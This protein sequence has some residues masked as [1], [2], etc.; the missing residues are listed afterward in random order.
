MV[1]CDTSLFRAARKNGRFLLCVLSKDPGL[2]PRP[3]ILSLSPASV[4]FV[5]ETAARLCSFANE[6][7]RPHNMLLTAFAT[8]FPSAF[9]KPLN[10]GQSAEHLS[11]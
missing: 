1:K 10:Y 3:P 4:N 7:F 9:W 8:A 2:E 11:L 6:M 5:F